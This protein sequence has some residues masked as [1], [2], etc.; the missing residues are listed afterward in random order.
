M[1]MYLKIK[2]DVIEDIKFE[3]FGC[4]SAIATSSMATEMIKGKTIKEALALTNEDVM[5]RWTDCPHT[6]FIALSWPRKPSNPP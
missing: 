3:T 1:R 2:N 6:K 4:A 5:N